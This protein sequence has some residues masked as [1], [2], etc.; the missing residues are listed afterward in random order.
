MMKKVFGWMMLF[1]FMFSALAEDGWMTDFEAAK[2]EAAKRNLPILAEFSG[3]DWCPPCMRLNEEV[4]SSAEFLDYA[5]DHVVLF[6][7]DFPRRTAQ[8]PE[9]KKQNNKLAE[10]YGVAYFPTILLLKADGTVIN[11]TGYQ[12]GGAASYVEHIKSLL[13]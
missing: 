5:K 4:F 6:L 9:L 8:D 7:A 1:G 2:K 11:K 12:A 13:K 3:S 10:Q